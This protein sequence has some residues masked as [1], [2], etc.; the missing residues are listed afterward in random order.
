MTSTADADKVAREARD[1]APIAAAAT[2][3][4]RGRWLEAIASDLDSHAAELS[5]LA[6]TETHIEEARLLGEI[7]RTTG[8]LRLFASMVDDGAYVEAIIDHADPDATPPRPDLRRMLIPLGP[9]AVFAASNFPFAFSVAGGDTASA[10]AV[11]CPVIV[12]AHEGHPETSRRT[13]QI[14]ELALA[15][16]GAPAGLFTLIEGRDAGI[17]LVQHPA[18]AAASF[19]GSGAG[20]RAL[21]DLAA[22]RPDPI[23]FYAE[24]GSINPVVI[25]RDAAEQRGAELAAGLVGSFT[26]G[27]GQLCTK[28]GVVIVPAGASFA[29]DVRTAL[30]QR[31]VAPA[32]LLTDKIGDAFADGVH[33]LSGRDG[34]ETVYGNGAGDGSPVLPVVLSTDAET[35]ISDPEALLE[36]HFGPTTLL[37]SYRSDDE[38]KQLLECLP[39][40]LTATVHAEAQEDVDELVRQLTPK[41]GR[42]LFSGWPTGVAVT[43]SQHHGGPWPATTSVHTSVGVTAARRFQRPLVFQDAPTSVLPSELQEDNPL[44]IPR[45]VDGALEV[46]HLV[47]AASDP[48]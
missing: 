6:A 34:V 27:A 35:V 37:V 18:M 43:W 42:V 45:R 16:A 47:A 28:P 31:A 17:A 26:L 14:V 41:A 9:I 3:E 8:Q 25:T 36:E 39:G 15:R 23:P 29:A 22:A 2:P 46:P 13:A 21:F 12:K 1:A 40:S 11:G 33:E 4:E 44:G 24:L 30:V 48:R 10:L 32:H 38:L 5:Q 20:G 7:A 19:T